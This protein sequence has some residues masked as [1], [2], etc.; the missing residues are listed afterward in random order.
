MKLAKKFTTLN[1]KNIQLKE[2]FYY[3]FSQPLKIDEFLGKTLYFATLFRYNRQESKLSP[4][5]KINIEAPPQKPERIEIKQIENRIRIQWARS[6]KNVSGEKL[7]QVLY[8]LAAFVDNQWKTIEDNYGFEY[9]EFEPETEG[10]FAFQVIAKIN[11]QIES[12]P[13][14]SATISFVDR[15]PPPVPEELITFSGRDHILLSWK[16]KMTRDFSH[17]RVYRKEAPRLPAIL[18]K[19]NLKESTFRDY[20]VADGA[21]YY[22]AVS[23]VDLRGNE[24]EATEFVKEYFIPEKN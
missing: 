3:S 19:D 7:Q 4:I 11:N 24:S 21:F 12:E 15:T 6:T 9:Y 23:A 1:I 5:V 17:W 13:V 18:I 20:N 8:K 2:G 16:Q 10:E 14:T 22:Y